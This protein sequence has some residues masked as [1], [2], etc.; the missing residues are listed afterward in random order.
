MAELH[1][2]DFQQVI[3]VFPDDLMNVQRQDN[4]IWKNYRAPVSAINQ[5]DTL[6]YN[7][8]H[9]INDVL[10]LELLPTLTDQTYLILNFWARYDP[11]V[12]PPNEHGRLVVTW[13]EPTFR[14]GTG[15]KLFDRSNGGTLGWDF[16]TGE[17]VASS[18]VANLFKSGSDVG[19]DA[20]D[21]TITFFIEYAIVDL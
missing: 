1:V 13:Y 2:Q 10:A 12:S 11:G 16:Q 6:I 14:M 5:L 15:L 4:G 21:G 7:E 17:N 8:D 9:D 20:G 19:V 18:V 3:E